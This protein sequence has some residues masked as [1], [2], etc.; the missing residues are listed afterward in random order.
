MGREGALR[1][2]TQFENVN[3]YGKYCGNRFI[4]AKTLE[5]KQ[6][7]NRSGF[8]ISKKLGT[9]VNR[10]RIRRLLK[11]V[12]RKQELKQGY[13]IVIGVRPEAASANYNQINEY[14]S[15]VLMRIGL[16]RQKDEMA[17]DRAN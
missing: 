17:G 1:K 11:E 4:W 14:L 2:S 12:L 10:N 15:E 8:I 5:N 6:N 13:D 3:K 16:I 9:A 7:L